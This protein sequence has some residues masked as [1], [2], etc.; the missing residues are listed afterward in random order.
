MQCINYYTE[1][2]ELFSIESDCKPSY[3]N[4]L[5][6]QQSFGAFFKNFIFVFSLEKY[7]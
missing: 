6:C 1:I 2:K 3:N 7:N 4:I 5:G